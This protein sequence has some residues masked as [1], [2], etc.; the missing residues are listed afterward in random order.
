MGKILIV[1]DD[2]SILELLKHMLESDGH[3]TVLA[4]NGK[5]AL[6]WLKEVKLDLVLLDL[7]LP[8]MDGME[9]CAS[10]KENPRTRSLPVVILTGN[11]SNVARIKSGLDVSADLFLSKPIEPK[12]LRAAVRKMLESAEKKR[13]LLRKSVKRTLD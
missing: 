1:E 13:M 3:M 8:D 5:S 4:E 7:M 9:I 10:I 6:Q 12:D 11:D 2:R